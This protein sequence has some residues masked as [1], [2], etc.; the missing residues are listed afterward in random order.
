M[1][2]CRYG[3]PVIPVGMVG[4]SLLAGSV[5]LSVSRWTHSREISMIG[6][7]PY[8]EGRRQNV[9]IGTPSSF[10]NQIIKPVRHILKKS[11]LRPQRPHR[12]AET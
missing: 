4:G 9:A 5:V 7:Y 6:I 8:P 11:D 12:I 1:Y 2:S 10:H 3:A